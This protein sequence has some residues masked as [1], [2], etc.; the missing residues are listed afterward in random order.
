[1]SQLKWLGREGEGEGGG[2]REKLRLREFSPPHL[3]VLIRPS[4]DDVHLHWGGKSA[5]FR[6]LI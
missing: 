6:L 3:L 1:M 5:L 4:P 2:K